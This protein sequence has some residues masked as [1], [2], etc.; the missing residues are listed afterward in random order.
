LLIRILVIL[1]FV[2]LTGCTSI[3]KT[4]CSISD[5][6]IEDIHPLL[7]TSET[8]PSLVGVQFHIH[9]TTEADQVL[10]IDSGMK[11]LR[12]EMAW[13]HFEINPGEYD[14]SYLDRQIGYA[15]AVGGKAIVIISYGNPLYNANG[16]WDSAEAELGM[17]NA[18]TALVERYVDDSIIWEIWN[19]PMNSQFWKGDKGAT[20]EEYMDLVKWMSSVIRA[21]DPDACL[22]G[23]AGSGIE[24]EFQE[25]LFDLGFL[26]Y[27]DGLSVHPYR[28]SKPK[29]I[30]ED[31]EELQ[32]AACARGKRLPVIISE[33]GY[34]EKQAG[35]LGLSQ[36]DLYLAMIKAAKEAK[37]SG[38]VIYDWRGGAEWSLVDDLSLEP[39]PGYYTLQE[40]LANE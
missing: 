34:T 7:A 27:V 6:S 24:L 15:Q 10:F 19:E 8:T 32:N 33:W 29:S 5:P 1:G 16:P 12:T 35:K 37:V 23:P 26:D 22:I 3:N 36:G 30:I 40:F 13:S 20:P 17:R 18:I 39:T 2:L 28:N 4:V 31:I 11:L 9:E 38:L 25:E 21:V 14:F